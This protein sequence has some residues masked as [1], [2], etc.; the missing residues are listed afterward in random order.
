M[1]LPQWLTVAKT[2]PPLWRDLKNK[3]GDPTPSLAN[4]V[5]AIR[6]LGIDCRYDLFHET[7]LVEYNGDV[8]ELKNFAGPL[9]NNTL[10]AVRSL[11]NNQFKLDVGDA[12]TVAAVMEIAR[13]NAF[14]PVLDYL[15]E[16]EGK[17]D[18]VPRIDTWLSDYCGAENNEFVRAIG[19]MHVV[20][21]VRRVRQPGV[22]FDYILVPLLSG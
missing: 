15:A 22:K 21:S 17:W 1:S 14:D 4:A 6:A 10:G 9:T 5:I 2:P 16:V 8:E 19:R 11:I 20:A 13:G 3:Y 12:N 7:I 18:G